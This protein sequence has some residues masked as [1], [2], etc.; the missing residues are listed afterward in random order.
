M[1]SKKTRIAAKGR[2]LKMKRLELGFTQRQFADAVGI[3]QQQLS[4]IENGR[5]GASEE[6]AMAIARRLRCDVDQVF[7]VRVPYGEAEEEEPHQAVAVANER[8][9]FAS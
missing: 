6:T 9:L 4:M 2:D 7:D 3:S 1:G 5:S 8:P